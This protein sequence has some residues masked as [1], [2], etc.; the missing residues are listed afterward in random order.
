[1]SK[2][3]L[4]VDD[5]AITRQLVALYLKAAGFG[6]VQAET[7][8]EALEKLAQEPVDIVVTDL[9][10]P[11]MDG[12]A[13]T[14]FLRGEDC[15]ARLPIVMLTTEFEDSERRKGLEAGVSVYLTKPV[16]Q[17][18]LGEVVRNLTP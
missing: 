13:L 7:G 15:Y 6:S 17:E 3:A 8:L 11:G 18:Q 1:M 14:K 2:Q 10:M 5:C 16:T 12:L 4:I 9:N